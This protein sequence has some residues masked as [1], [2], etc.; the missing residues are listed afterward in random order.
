[1]RRLHRPPNRRARRSRGTPVRGGTLE[2]VGQSDVDHLATT[3]VFTSLDLVSCS[4]C[5]PAVRLPALRDLAIKLQPAPDLAREVPTRENG[6]VSADGLTYTFGLRRG[7]R[8]NSRRPRDV[9]RGGRR[10]RVQD[11]LQPGR[12]RRAPVLYQSLVD[13]L[14]AFCDAFARV[15]APSTR[16]GDS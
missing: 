13:G 6:G 9:G 5:A 7:V 10:A 4:P 8:W 11:A 3:G 12:P 1:M 15:P 16:S 14:A 2:I